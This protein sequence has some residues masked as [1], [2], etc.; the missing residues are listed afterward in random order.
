M[1]C[2]SLREFARIVRSGG[3]IIF[4]VVP[5]AWV[6]YGYADILLELET[7]GKIS[8]ESRGKSFQM[9]PT[10]EPDFLCEIWVMTVH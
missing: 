5:D 8:V 9:L 6:E 3:Y 2:V 10:T 7:A 4:A 1:P